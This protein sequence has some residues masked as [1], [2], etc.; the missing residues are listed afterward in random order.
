VSAADRMSRRRRR[1]E[2]AR[3]KSL[4]RNGRPRVVPLYFIGGL[5]SPF[6]GA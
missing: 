2:T 4:H 5:S 1:R 6:C 3:R